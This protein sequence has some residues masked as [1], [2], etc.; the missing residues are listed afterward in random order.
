MIFR[1]NDA[2]RLRCRRTNAGSAM[3]RALKAIA[4]KGDMTPEDFK[5]AVI[6]VCD[7]KDKADSVV[8]EMRAR[9]LIQ[10][11]VKLTELGEFLSRQGTVRGR[12]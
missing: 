2:T 3:D 10:R 6:S 4:F 5:R 12:V 7:T 1:I 8:Y 9:G 11:S